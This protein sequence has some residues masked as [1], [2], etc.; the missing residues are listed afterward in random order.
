M[1]TVTRKMQKIFIVVSGLFV[2]SPE[3]MA[4]GSERR[5]ILGNI[6]E[7]LLIFV[8]SKMQMSQSHEFAI[9]SSEKPEKLTSS[10]QEI[11]KQINAL[12]SISSRVNVSTIFQYIQTQFPAPINNSYPNTIQIIYITGE[13]PFT[14]FLGHSLLFHPDVYI[15]L[16]YFFATGVNENQITQFSSQL[17]QKNPSKSFLFS[18]KSS[19]DLVRAVS[20]LTAHPQQRQPLIEIEMNLNL[21]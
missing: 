16:I 8:L 17:N 14:M 15:D 4:Q 10:I 5:T 18:I 11:H 13:V 1:E 12:D 9:L 7:S 3:P 21:K 19:V 6:K 20:L 2:E